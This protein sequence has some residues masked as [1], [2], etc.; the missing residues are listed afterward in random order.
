MSC[1]E[2]QGKDFTVREAALAAIVGLEIPSEYQAVHHDLQCRTRR[3]SAGADIEI[4]CEDPVGMD[5][6]GNVLV[7]IVMPDPDWLSSK[8]ADAENFFVDGHVRDGTVRVVYAV[9]PGSES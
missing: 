4:G 5:S 7:V 2:I 1:L 8:N 9:Q 3:G 6:Q